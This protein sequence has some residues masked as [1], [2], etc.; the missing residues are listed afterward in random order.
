[1]VKLGSPAD[2]RREWDAYRTLVENFSP[3]NTARIQKEPILSD[4]R[5]RALLRYTFAGGDPRR[6]TCSL[7]TYYQD[8]GGAATAQILKPVV[9]VYGR[10]WWSQNIPRTFALSEEYDRLLPT[11]LKL[12]SEASGETQFHPTDM[13]SVLVA[14]EVNVL[15]LQALS[16]GQQVRLHDFRVSKV[17][18]D[19][20]EMTLIASPPPGEASAYLRLRLEGIDPTAYRP[21][22][23][24]PVLDAVITATRH[25]L[26]KDK[27][28]ATMTGLDF[29]ATEVSLGNMICPNPLH[30]YVNLLDHVTESRF[31]IIHGDLNLE[32]ILVDSETGFAWL[33][34]FADTRRGPALYDLQRLE[35]QVIT[36]L[37]PA[38]VTEARLGPEVMVELYQALHADMPDPT[39]PHPALQEPYTFLVTIR[40]LARQ[41]LMDDVEWDEYYRGL[42]L[43]LLGSLKFAEIDVTGRALAFAGAAAAQRLIGRSLRAPLV[44]RD[45]EPTSILQRPMIITSVLILLI[46]I[47]VAGWLLLQ[48]PPTI[49][50]DAPLALI[51]GLE[52]RV[53]VRRQAADRVQPATFGL[54]LFPEDAVLTYEM[55]AANVLCRNGL[56]F[57]VRASQILVVRC[58]ET[59]DY[60]ALG[61]LDPQVSGRLIQARGEITVT[62]APAG[63]RA[64]RADV[65]RVPSLVGPRNTA[66]IEPRPTWRWQE[67]ADTEGYRLSMVNA[68]TGERWEVETT[69]TGLTYPDDAPPLVP[70]TTYLTRLELLGTPDQVDESFFFLLDEAGRNEVAATETAIRALSLDRPTEGFLLASFY[71]DRELWDA[72]ITQLESIIEE[73]ENSELAIQLG[74]LYFQVGLYARAEASYQA[75]LAA[76][77]LVDDPAAQAGALVGQG[78]VADAYDEKKAAIDH[79]QAA[80]DLYRT[81]GDLA[82]AEVVAQVLAELVGNSELEK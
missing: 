26:L 67:M 12:R 78:R 29:D 14:G 19:R 21:G 53:E 32:N 63:T 74:D 76:A 43:T 61:R 4:D 39:A 36:K 23:Q 41:F 54:G 45:H 80:E 56:L 20:G 10:Q 62:L 71:R 18:P 58:Q 35:A 25:S 68:I 2:L 72:A 44:Y 66:I 6:P 81:A 15:A 28:Q 46:A 24:I 33:I 65:G 49:P 77:R 34:D 82:R 22:D 31:S 75:A 1:M 70:N 79:F 38:T 27:A 16:P 5:Q 8:Q 51:A 60:Q 59:D 57:N 13:P 7:R 47:A 40:R 37:L 11:H 42:I 50:I 9:R 52:G 55:A 64:V 73:V 48:R 17:R 30:A 69:A 3:Q